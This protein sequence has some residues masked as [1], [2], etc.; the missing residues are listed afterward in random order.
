MSEK[1]DLEN[2]S[3]LNCVKTNCQIPLTVSAFDQILITYIN[4]VFDI[5]IQL[6]ITTQSF[7]ITGETETW[8]QAGI[9]TE[10]NLM[11][12][13]Q[14]VLRVKLLFDPPATTHVSEAYKE[15]INEMAWR[16]TIVGGD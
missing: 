11:A 12:K 7:G 5:F 9:A 13:T 1:F 2:E 8:D 3:I 10:Q 15:M 14:M 16:S 6:G 4:S